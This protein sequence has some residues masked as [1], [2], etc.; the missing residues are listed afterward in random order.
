VTVAVR[1]APDEGRYEVTVDGELAGFAEYT[2]RR[3]TLAL[4]H[5]EVFDRFA[6]QGLAGRLAA[7]ALDDARARGEHVQPFCP[8]VRK[9]IR[10]H[11]EHLDLVAA[12]D[13]G[14]FDLPAAG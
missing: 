14:R 9:F 3:G 4:T 5:T 13:R 2:R 7:F 1:D 12:G 6:G 11:P 10:E 8:Y